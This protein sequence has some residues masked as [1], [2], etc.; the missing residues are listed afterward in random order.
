MGNY[1]CW[2]IKNGYCKSK[3]FNIKW[4]P[5]SMEMILTCRKCSKER[6]FFNCIMLSWQTR[7]I[8][9]TADLKFIYKNL[10]KNRE[11]I[12]SLRKSEQEKGA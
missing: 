4:S 6:V 12:S 8:H 10:I 5:S 11:L 7:D 1:T 2:T 9:N 3:D